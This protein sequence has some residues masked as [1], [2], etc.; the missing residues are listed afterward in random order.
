[1]KYA[2]VKQNYMVKLIN[3]TENRFEKKNTLT[4]LALVR[5][6]PGQA[7]N[8]WKDQNAKNVENVANKGAFQ[9]S[10]LSK[11]WSM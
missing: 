5:A 3:P 7:Q 8:D 2:S 6:M 4:F 11:G 10:V 1:M 9:E